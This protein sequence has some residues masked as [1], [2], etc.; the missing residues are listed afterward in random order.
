[1]S[2]DKSSY[3]RIPNAE[4]VFTEGT[5]SPYNVKYD[6]IDGVGPV[7]IATSEY[8]APTGFSSQ[9]KQIRTSDGTLYAV[10]HKQLAG[11]YQIYVKKSTDGVTW[12]DET[13][14]STYSEMESYPQSVPSIAVDS[15][16]HLH[17]VWGGKATGYTVANQI[18]YAEYTDFWQ[19]PT[20]VS[21]YGDGGDMGNFIQAN[22]CIAVDSDDRL[23]V[24]WFGK[25]PFR[26][27]HQ[28]W[29]RKYT[30]SWGGIV[31][32]ST[33]GNMAV[34]DQLYPSIAVDS[35]DYLH[36]VW[37]G[38]ATGYIDYNKIWYAVYTD[39]WATPVCL[40]P[41]GQ[42]TYPNLRWSRWP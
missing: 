16:D 37:I 31:R 41:T 32:I 24:V 30:M 21:G 29:Y 12:T 26:A 6:T 33:Y 9:R 28:I 8:V 40:Q 22:P 7:G 36:V 4:Y 27:Q 3:V 2:D 13:R 34:N 18:W 14:I 23:H 1:V 25:S 39:S 19:T 5:A 38:K 10:Y 15:Q 35:Q 42:N 11:Q 17:V 20:R